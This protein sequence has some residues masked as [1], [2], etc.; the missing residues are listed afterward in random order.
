VV[1]EWGN[2]EIRDRREGEGER[3]M[4]GRVVGGGEGGW[5]EGELAS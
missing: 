2:G 4:S 1:A 5:G 3:G